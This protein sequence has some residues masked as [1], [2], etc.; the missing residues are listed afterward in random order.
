MKIDWGDTAA[1]F[2]NPYVGAAR[3]F[4]NAIGGGGSD[5][6]NPLAGQNAVISKTER[7][8][9]MEAGRK[10]GQE[11]FYD[12]EMT[13]LRNRYQDL[14]KGYSGQEL[15]ALRSTSKNQVADQQRAYSNQLA[16]NL[17]RQGVGGARAAAMQGA[18]N[19]KFNQNT[20]A[21]ERGLTAD[22][23]ALIR[24]GQDKLS[25]FILG[26]KYGGLGTEI[27]YAQLGVNERGAAQAAAANQ[28]GKTN[29]LINDD[30]PLIGWL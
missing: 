14:S 10:R 4:S 9:D 7:E 19:Q 12:K 24:S 13:D 11:I 1:W 26:Q 25:D 20:A 6:S 5:G 2:I 8:K 29:G 18:A 28:K 22:N 27:G 16:S 23:A 3:T 17:A 21:F 15:G 30:I